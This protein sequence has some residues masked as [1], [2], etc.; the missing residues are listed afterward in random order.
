[1]SIL[2]MI[3][4]VSANAA[5]YLPTLG[6][7]AG[8]VGVAEGPLSLFLLSLH[9]TRDHWHPLLQLYMSSIIVKFSRWKGRPTSF[10][11]IHYGRVLDERSEVR[12][13]ENPKALIPTKSI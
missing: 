2:E 11:T 8:D 12:G 5:T 6:G 7:H 3:V 4:L 10:E 13:E 9:V 1:M